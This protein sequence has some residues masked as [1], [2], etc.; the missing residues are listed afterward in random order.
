MNSLDKMWFLALPNRSS[1]SL[2]AVP[3]NPIPDCHCPLQEDQ[4]SHNSH[5]D[6]YNNLLLGLC[7]Q[8]VCQTF[9]CILCCDVDW[10]SKVEMVNSIGIACCNTLLVTAHGIPQ[11]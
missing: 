1:Q 11:R 7:G 10:M 9:D 5:Y 8:A 2:P 6:G 3:H 4:L